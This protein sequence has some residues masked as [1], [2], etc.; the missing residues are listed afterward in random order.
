MH[1]TCLLLVPPI[2]QQQQDQTYQRYLA[3]GQTFPADLSGDQ[4]DRIHAYLLR[5]CEQQFGPRFRY[6]FFAEVRKEQAAFF[7][8]PRLR[9]KAGDWTHDTG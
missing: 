1:I 2:T 6:D 5:K 4:A 9:A 7:P 8:P 3:A